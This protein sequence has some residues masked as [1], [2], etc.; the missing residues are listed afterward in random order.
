MTI[1]ATDLP[2]F[3]ANQASLTDIVLRAM[4][5]TDSPRLAEIVRSLVTHLHDFAREVRLSEQEFEFG[6]D[7]LNRI[8]QATNDNHNEGIPMSD[9]LGFSTLICLLNNGDDG[10]TETDAALFGPFRLMNSPRTSNGNSIVRCTTPGPALFAEILIVDDAGKPIEGVDVDVWQASTVGLHENQDDGQ[11]DM[12]L[13]GKFMT[14]ADGKILFR[15]IKPAGYPVPTDGPA[16]ELLRVQHRHPYR[17]A[18]VHLLG[19]K[20][21][22]K[23]LITQIFVN[24]DSNLESDVV[25]GVTSS[26]VGNFQQLRGPA[27]DGSEGPWYRL[28]HRLVMKPGE[29]VL[30]IP[31]I[32]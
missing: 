3:V 11:A 32:K 18:H 30:P 21:G 16:G 31:P 9:V 7:F 10:A 25:F 8:G 27:P 22:Y 26:L 23:T 15:S 4:S 28:E 5:H 2:N 24:N 29:A 19:F 14:G 6:I 1:S 17:P 12:N 20:E 13:R